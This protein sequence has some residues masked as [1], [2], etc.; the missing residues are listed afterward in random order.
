MIIDIA[1]VLLMLLAIFKGFSKGLIVG[2]FSLLA[3]IIGLAAALKLSVLVAVY[4]KN[5]VLAST[6]WLPLLS[7]I[8]VFIV[9]VL[10]VSIGARIIKKTM[11]FAMLGWL[12]KLCGI[13]LYVIIYII[14]F[15]IFLF[16]AEKV[17]LIKPQTI[18]ESQ[19]YQYVAPWGP[20]VI[21]NIG[22]VIPIFKDMFTQLQNFFA[23]LAQKSA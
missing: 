9:V 8:L 14:I 4:L 21:D 7:F 6:K 2:I 23:T 11:Q 18:A 15:S 19:V 5:S 1:F 10:L 12:D 16:Y 17:F 3:L 13:F 20:K 22:K